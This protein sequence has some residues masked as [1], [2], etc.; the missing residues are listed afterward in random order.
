MYKT[1]RFLWHAWNVMQYPSDSNA[2][3]EMTNEDPRQIGPRA[4]RLYRGKRRRIYSAIGRFSDQCPTKMCISRRWFTAM[5][6]SLSFVSRRPPYGIRVFQH[7][8]FSKRGVQPGSQRFNHGNT[9]WVPWKTHRETD[10]MRTVCLWRGLIRCPLSGTELECDTPV[11]YS[12]RACFQLGK[13]TFP[14]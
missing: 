2:R 5:R 1:V 13:C 7:W 3:S 10:G 11:K 4:Y 8:L 12:A 6:E 14:R 9:M